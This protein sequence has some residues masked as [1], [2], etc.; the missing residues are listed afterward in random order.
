[1]KDKTQHTHCWSKSETS[2]LSSFRCFSLSCS[3][4][5]ANHFIKAL[6]ALNGCQS[7]GYLSK[8][9]AHAVFLKA[10][11]FRKSLHFISY[12]TEPNANVP[13]HFHT[14]YQLSFI[15][16]ENNNGKTVE[17]HI[18][19]IGPKCPSAACRTLCLRAGR[20]TCQ[21]HKLGVSVKPGRWFVKEN[22]LVA[23][24]NKQHKQK[25]EWS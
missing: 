18:G 10:K 20:L 2:D 25:H 21:T 6:L 16:A 4:Q 8:D 1:M 24:Q 9:L 17:F 5:D 12:L 15:C 13:L 19:V 14:F 7:R 11:P 22:G 3:Q 23:K